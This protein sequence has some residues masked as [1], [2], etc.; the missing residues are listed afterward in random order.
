MCENF[1]YSF[2]Y[3]S[4]ARIVSLLIALPWEEVALRVAL[5]VAHIADDFLRWQ[6]LRNFCFT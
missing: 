4:C 6:G 3:T 5:R 1:A 2:L